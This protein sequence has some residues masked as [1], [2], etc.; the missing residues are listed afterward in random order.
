MKTK[1][2]AAIIILSYFSLKASAQFKKENFNFHYQTTVVTQKNFKSKKPLINPYSYTFGTKD[3]VATTLTTSGF[4]GWRIANNTE[5]YFNTEIAAG[6]GLNLAR[7]LGGFVNGESFRVSNPAPAFYIARVYLNHYFPLTAERENLNDGINQVKGSRPQKYIRVLAGKLAMTDFF[8]NNTYSH[9]SRTQFFNWALMS[10]GAWD[11]PANTRGY[12]VG[13]MIEY[14]NTP[15]NVAYRFAWSLPPSTANGHKL[16]YNIQQAMCYTGEVERKF[17][18]FKKDITIR[19]L[20]F[21]N[22]AMMGVYTDAT[23][24]ISQ[25]PPYIILQHNNYHIKYGYSIN[26]EI[27]LNDWSGVFMRAGYND[28]KTETWVFT[29]IDGSVSLG[30]A[31]NGKKWKRKDDYCGIAVLANTLSHE[32]QNYLKAG[33]YGFMLGDGSLN[34]APEM[35]AEIYYNFALF[36]GPIFVSPNYQIIINAGYNKDNHAPNHVIGARVHVRF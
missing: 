36:N 27:K 6:T 34:Y 5:I 19:A 15:K 29:E 2:A 16:D 8:D 22:R 24:I 26:S 33:G 14:R 10:S 20:A 1:K 23:P 17:S 13:A 12:T 31:A 30:Y 18:L 11:Y 9:D 7:G 4:S 25:T 28:G 3:E 32:H 21:V 35:I